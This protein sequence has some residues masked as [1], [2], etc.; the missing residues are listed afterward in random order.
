MLIPVPYNFLSYLPALVVGEMWIGVCLAVVIEMVPLTVA[1]AAVAIFLFVIN[2]IG[3]CVNLL[4]P[5]LKTAFGMK[6]ALLILVAGPYALAGCVF[7]LIVIGLK[8]KS[9]CRRSTSE[10]I[11]DEEERA[12]LLEESQEWSNARPRHSSPPV[13]ILTTE[14][15]VIGAVSVNDDSSSDSDDD[16]M[17]ESLI[18]L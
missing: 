9:R 3:G 16:G 6:Y 14:G 11:E 18:R 1:A 4:V 2:N 5:P 17:T 10:D 13:P 15:A 8:V 12:Q 7:L